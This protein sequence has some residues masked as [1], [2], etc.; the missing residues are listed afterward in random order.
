M[1]LFSKGGYRQPERHRRQSARHQLKKTRQAL[2]LLVWLGLGFAVI[3]AMTAPFMNPNHM[4]W[5]RFALYY[6][7]GSGVTALTCGLLKLIEVKV[8]AHGKGDDAP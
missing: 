3:F 6:A 1:A 8:Y 5:L 7:G 2:W 4:R